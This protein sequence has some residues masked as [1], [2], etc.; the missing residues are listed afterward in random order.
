MTVLSQRALNRALLDRQLLLDR[1]RMPAIDAVRHLAG[2]QAQAPNPPY[3]GLWT[4]LAGFR[5]DDLAQLIL[6][7]RVVRIALMRG[8]VHLVTADDCLMLRPLV[9][10]LFLNDLDK[11]LAH[12]AELAGVDRAKLAEVG[13]ALVEERP[14]TPKELG[15]LLAEHWPGHAPASLVHGVR[16]L[17]PLVQVPPRGIWG[18]GGQTTLTTAE[19]WLGRP[20]D[21]APSI[22]ELVLRYLAAYGPATAAD[23]QTWSGVTGLGEIVERLR[24]RLRT[25]RD[26]KGRELFDLPDAPRPDPDTPAPA[27]LLPEYDNITLSHADRTR[28]VPEEYRKRL[29]TINGIIPGTLLVDGMV[30]GQWKLTRARRA[31]TVRITP[32]HPLSTVDTEATRTEVAALLE[33]AAP[34]D[35]HD[36]VIDKQ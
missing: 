18:R 29:M 35:S 14:R 32:F 36:V 6:D 33:F 25:F 2:M 9:Q 10:P 15:P 16:G 1:A 23:A 3:V 5:P 28:V 17:L 27:R 4:R 19:Y 34:G 21:P 24:P 30:A 22:D 7:R 11:N 8:T 20:L 31:A 13:R 12:R 26:E